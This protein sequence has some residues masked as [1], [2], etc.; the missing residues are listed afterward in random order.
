MKLCSKCGEYKYFKEYGKDKR[1]KSGLKSECKDCSN[2]Y[3]VWRNMMR[4]CYNP[5][6][7][8]YKNYGGRGI[9]VCKKWQEYKGMESFIEKYWKK[10]LQLDRIDND[11]GY[12]PDNCRF[13]TSSENLNNRRSYGGVKYRGVSFDKITNNYKTS[14][15]VQGKLIFLGRFNTPIEAAKAYDKYVIENNLERKLNF[16]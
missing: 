2:K 8:N 6:S 11:K 9:T 12:S 15:K 7:S 16:I 14:I 10:G 4:R 13:V 5:S 3:N 1:N